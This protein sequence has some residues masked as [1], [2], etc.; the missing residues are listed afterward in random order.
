MSNYGS[1][2]D[3]NDRRSSTTTADPSANRRASGGF[4]LD[5]TSTGGPTRFLHA[6]K[7]V[8]ISRRLEKMAK[9][10][11]ES[12]L[13]HAAAPSARSDITMD[14]LL[15]TSQ[16]KLT[17]PTEAPEDEQMEKPSVS[18]YLISIV[19]GKG[20]V[21]WC[22]AAGPLAIACN[23]WQ[24][25][26]TAKFWLNFLVM[27]PLAS[28]LGDFTEEVALHTNEVGDRLRFVVVV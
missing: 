2:G 25:S 26:D 11:S 12:H 28:I 4:S 15:P 6:V 7:A 24:W 10:K 16:H 1:T 22:L 19:F 27:I 13:M 3:T 14:S 21:S 23:I 8:Q 17:T 9:M 18:E 20:V 5:G